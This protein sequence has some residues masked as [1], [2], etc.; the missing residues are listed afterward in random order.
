MRNRMGVWMWMWMALVCCGSADDDS[1]EQSTTDK[2]DTDTDTDTDTDADTD[3]D[4]D[5]EQTIPVQ[6]SGSINS[7]AGNP[8]EGATVSIDDTS[9]TTT[10]D[11]DGAWALADVPG[12]ANLLLKWEHTDYVPTAFT[13]NTAEEDVV[14]DA[15]MIVPFEAILNAGIVGVTLDLETNG[16]VGFAARS[17]PGEGN[18]IAGVSVAVSPNDVDGPYYVGESGI[19]SGDL[20]ET[21]AGSG[22]GAG[23]VLNVPPG[24]HTLTYS[25]DT[26][27]EC[28]PDDLGWAAGVN[29]VTVPITAGWFTI[30][31]MTCT[32]P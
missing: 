19:P 9:L 3:T 27:V 17:A 1:T 6:V 11:A 7:F 28:A 2:S 25:G 10:T 13:L 21:Q 14:L 32:T 30:T 5:V 18:G 4:T 16:M 20:T 22:D 12:D 15:I 23:T 31:A 24:D 8:I 26:I 29:A